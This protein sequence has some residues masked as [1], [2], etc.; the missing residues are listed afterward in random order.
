M[1]MNAQTPSTG[2][3]A[4]ALRNKYNNLKTDLIHACKKRYLGLDVLAEEERNPPRSAIDPKAGG[5]A[6]PRARLGDKDFPP[7]KAL[8]PGKYPV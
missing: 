3:Q 5:I 6:N 2:Y 4:K 8:G 1:K 7:Q